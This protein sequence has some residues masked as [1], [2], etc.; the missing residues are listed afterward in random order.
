MT[1]RDFNAWYQEVRYAPR[2]Q[3]PPANL[4]ETSELRYKD[5]LDAARVFNRLQ[6]NQYG[7]PIRRK[8]KLPCRRT[9]AHHKGRVTLDES[10][11]QYRPS[12]RYHEHRIADRELNPNDL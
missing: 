8:N 10:S 6:G 9:D 5:I 3:Q 1:G 2:D 7:P 4:E 12:V 11:N